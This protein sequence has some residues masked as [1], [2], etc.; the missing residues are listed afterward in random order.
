MSE[1]KT[2]PKIDTVLAREEKWGREFEALRRFALD[3]GLFEDL[4]WGCPCYSLG[5]GNVVLIHGFKE[6][7]AYLFFKG[8]LMTDPDGILV[9]Q[10]ENVQAARQVRFT[11]LEQIAGMEAV[12]KD[13]IHR[14]IAVE[15]A[16]LK[17]EFKK[18][19]DFAMPDEFRDR[20][21]EDPDLSAAFDALTPG[22]QKAYLLHFSSAKQA[23][24]RE[25]RIDKAAPRILEGKGLDD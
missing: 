1:R 25:T 9:Q 10:T 18:T 6:Y 14:A 15:K 7:C 8:A 24:T 4:K 13:Y 20:L 5:K 21:A 22:R 23:K 19:A 16:G 2:N 3:C 11:G 12:L 17:V